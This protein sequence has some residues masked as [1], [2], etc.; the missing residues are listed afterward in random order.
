MVG[1]LDAR[2]S[3]LF[4]LLFLLNQE[5]A[6]VA[7]RVNEIIVNEHLE[8]AVQTHFGQFGAQLRVVLREIVN[9]LGIFDIIF[10]QDILALVVRLWELDQLLKPFKIFLELA[11][12]IAFN[13]EICLFNHH[14]EQLVLGQ[15]DFD[16][17]HAP[18]FAQIVREIENQV[19][20]LLQTVHDPRVPHLDHDF[21]I[22]IFQLGL[23]DLADDAGGN[24]FLLNFID[25][26]VDPVVDQDLKGVLEAVYGGLLAQ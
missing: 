9:I 11:Q 4:F 18:D 2:D 25:L 19:Q 22:V 1:L 15:R 20:I 23:V 26:V 10:D 3:V 8:E 21:L 17:P 5:V 14:F 16:P 24:G 12:I 13:T 6:R 7:V